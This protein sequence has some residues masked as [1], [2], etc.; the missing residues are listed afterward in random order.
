MMDSVIIAALTIQQLCFKTFKP[1]MHVVQIFIDSFYWCKILKDDVFFNNTK[2]VN[3][4]Q[5]IINFNVLRAS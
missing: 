5:P 3:L 4:I 1:C 2:Q